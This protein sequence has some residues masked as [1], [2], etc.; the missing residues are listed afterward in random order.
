MGYGYDEPNSLYHNDGN[1]NNWLLFKLVGV[2][3][4]RAAVGARVRVE[5]TIN[6]ET[7]R[8]VREISGNHA[9]Q[10]DLRPHFG[11][12]PATN[13]DLVRIEW[14]SGIVEEFTNVAPR[15]ILTFVEPSLKGSIVQDGKFHVAMTMSTNRVYQPQASADVVAWTVLTYWIGSDSC[16]PI[17]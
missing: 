9:W 7:V 13:V 14:P 6:G 16:T 17:E 1:S 11:L 8:Q 5:A 10:D 4:N 12:G 15:Q 3:S 2:R